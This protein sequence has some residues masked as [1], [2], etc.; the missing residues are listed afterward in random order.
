MHDLRLNK[1]VLVRLSI[2]C[3]DGNLFVAHPARFRLGPGSGR[4]LFG[5]T[6]LRYPHLLDSDFLL[7][8][9]ARLRSG[10][11]A[12]H[13]LEPSCHLPERGETRPSG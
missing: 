1:R 3:S 4:E 7:Q 10:E 2:P 13:D 6:E 9:L 5:G 12:F 11:D 8:I